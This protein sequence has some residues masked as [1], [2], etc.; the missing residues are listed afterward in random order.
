MKLYAIVRSFVWSGTVLCTLTTCRGQDA[1]TSRKPIEVPETEMAK[2][3]AN[4]VAPEL[5]KGALREC[6]NALVML[7]ITIDESG[8]VISEEFVSGFSEFNES[9][10][11]AVK[12]WTYKPYEKHGH[13]VAVQ[14]RVS[15]FYL[16][17]GESFPMY[18]PDGKGGVKGGNTL[19]LPP[20]CGPGVV[21][22]RTP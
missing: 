21:V 13:A 12:Q 10:T 20:G 6:S 18:S 1:T 9:A 22:K 19:P 5:P 4:A 8:S 17:D 3:L 14:T 11:A 7:R 15:I 2:R 16:G